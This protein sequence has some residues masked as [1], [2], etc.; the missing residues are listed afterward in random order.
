MSDYKYKKGDIVY[1]YDTDSCEVVKLKVRH[2]MSGWDSDDWEYY[3][4]TGENYDEDGDD[5]WEVSQNRLFP[6]KVRAM[7]Y[8]VDRV[9]KKMEKNKRK[10]EK[11]MNKLCRFQ[12]E[13]EKVS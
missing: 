1:H 6:S 7:E 2:T 12:G 5:I 4:C 9:Q 8:A 13:L 11:L 10:K 3:N